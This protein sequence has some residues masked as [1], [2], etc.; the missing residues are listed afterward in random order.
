MARSYRP[1]LRDQEFLLPPSMA[2]WLGEDHLVWFV[3]DVVGQLDTSRFHA[4][5]RRGGVG[6]QG[7][8]PD[9]LLGLLIYAYAVGERSSRR[10]E[11]LCAD[12]VAF[13][14]A[15]GSDVPDHTTI[16][17]FRAEHQD[18]FA[19]VFAQVLRL[20][21]AAGMV[22]VGTIAI[23]GTKIAA[24]ASRG[25]NRTA[26]TV[27]EE[28][29][30]IAQEILDQAAGTDTA[31]D[32][33]A[34]A[35]GGGSDDDLPPGFESRS[36]R[37]ANIKKALAELDAQDA[38]RAA[39]DTV[40]QAA[41]AARAEEY[42]RR[43]EAGE[44]VMGRPPAGVD[45]VRV[46]R[47]RI[48]RIEGLL[49]DLAGADGHGDARRRDDLKRALGRARAA[50]TAAEA[51]TTAGRLDSRGGSQRA[52]DRRAAARKSDGLVNTTDPDSRLMTHG[53]GSGSVQGYNAQFA[54]TDD[55]FILGVHLA[56]D[57]NDTDCYIPTLAAAVLQAAALGEDIDLVLADAGYFT[58]ANLTT[59]G[60]D[61]LIA[62]GKN[63][64]IHAAVDPDAGPVPD[65]LDPAQGMRQRLKNPAN[66][67][68]YKRRS[69]TVEPVFAHLKDQIGLRRFA[70]RGLQAVTAELHL[71][72]AAVNLNRLH[73]AALTT[74]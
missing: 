14:V 35:R 48:A 71:A 73:R 53:S 43:V 55:H 7:Y 27:R 37:A 60:P 39:A 20:C 54:V 70:R 56:Q 25:A 45:S 65:D 1:V 38:E 52:R 31:E 2:D 5:S 64:D 36:G 24:N 29:R 21:S 19:E 17:R 63:R 62:P 15:C 16:A 40:A 46:A 30:R 22:R 50:L 28:A 69:A 32:H 41:D 44:A 4:R 61:R 3:L 66:A 10:I 34:V 59:P 74:S 42:L 8:D 18:A 58:D 47:A 33:A 57:A 23:D 26:D 68:A 67:T 12:H 9:M 72:A 51:D 6:R 13:R 49:A 11:R